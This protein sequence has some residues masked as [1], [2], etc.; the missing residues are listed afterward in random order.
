MNLN[1]RSADQTLNYRVVLLVGVIKIFAWGNAVEQMTCML[2]T[3]ARTKIVVLA[4]RHPIPRT[5]IK[6]ICQRINLILITSLTH[7][8]S[9]RLEAAA[10]LTR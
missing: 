7:C 4:A 3:S 2:T 1:V 6:D 5:I 9:G 8:S 10:Y